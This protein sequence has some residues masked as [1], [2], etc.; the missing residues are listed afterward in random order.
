VR[1][2]TIRVVLTAGGATVITAEAL[3]VG[4]P[5]RS[6]GPIR[7]GCFG[8]GFDEDESLVADVGDDLQAAAEG[9]EGG[10][11][12]AQFGGAWLGVLD[13]GHA[14]MV[15]AYPGSD[16]G[17]SDAEAARHLGEPEGALLGTQLLHPCGD[18]GLV[19]RIGIELGEKL[20][21]GVVVKLIAVHRM[22]SCFRSS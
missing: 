10:G 1:G 16:L 19:G 5:G 6:R 7:S 9:L 13:G 12:G 4:V 15:I 22:S 8:A 18:G 14:A 17:L 20:I 11:Q 2:A 21:L 3:G